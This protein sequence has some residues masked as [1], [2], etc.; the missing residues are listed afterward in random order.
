M[1]VCICGRGVAVRPGAGR[2]ARHCS[3]ACRQRAYRMR[4]VPAELT[5]GRRWTRA[6]GKRPVMTS[7]RPA[8]STDPATWSTFAAVRSAGVG[9][10]FGVMLGGGLGCYDLDH[11]TL[12]QVRAFVRSVP[13]PVVYVERSVSGDGAHV[14]VLAPEGPGTKRLIDGVHVERYTRA[15]FIRTT[16]DRL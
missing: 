10:G 1:A 13:E 5:A 8:S 11:V 9:D 4:Q 12:E 7:G 15:R 6:D 3:A 2:R 14:F 16:L